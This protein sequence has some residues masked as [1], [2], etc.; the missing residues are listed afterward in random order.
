MHV[1]ALGPAHRL[2]LLPRSTEAR[3]KKEAGLLLGDREVVEACAHVALVR[4]QRTLTAACRRLCLRSC[5][6]LSTRQAL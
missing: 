3:E 5:W 4:A 1:R 2:T 6:I